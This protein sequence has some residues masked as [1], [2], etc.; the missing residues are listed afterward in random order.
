MYYYPNLLCTHTLT[1][2]LYSYL[3][4]ILCLIHRAD[5][6]LRHGRIDCALHRGQR[7]HSAHHSGC[8]INLHLPARLHADR[9]QSAKAGDRYTGV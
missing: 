5:L 6:P 2:V 3:Y 1:N 9:G 4:Y 7:Q 8:S